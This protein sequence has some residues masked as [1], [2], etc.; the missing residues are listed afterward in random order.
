MRASVDLGDASLESFPSLRLASLAPR[1]DVRAVSLTLGD[2]VAAPRVGKWA[3]LPPRLPA[4]PY[5][6]WRDHDF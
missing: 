6:D 5:R 1:G 4:M 2:A 3:P